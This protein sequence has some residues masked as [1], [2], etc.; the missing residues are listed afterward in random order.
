MKKKP[1]IIGFLDEFSPQNTAN[2]Q[3]LWSL[4]KPVIT[5]NTSRLRANSDSTP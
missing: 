4:T 5:K 2:T 3:R 1:D